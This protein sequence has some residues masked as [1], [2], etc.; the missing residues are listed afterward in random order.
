MHITDWC[1]AATGFFNVVLYLH[2]I[3]RGAFLYIQIIT[4]DVNITC[5]TEFYGNEYTNGIVASC[6]SVKIST[7]F[8]QAKK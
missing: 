1:C 8:L 2:T 7:H 4:G 5:C 6:V 3:R